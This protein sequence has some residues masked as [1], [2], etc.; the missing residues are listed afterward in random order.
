MKKVLWIVLGIVLVVVVCI[1]LTMSG[2][3]PK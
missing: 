1:L 3:G 2:L